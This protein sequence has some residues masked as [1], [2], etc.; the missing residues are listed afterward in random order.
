MNYFLNFE[1]FVNKLLSNKLFKLL[2]IIITF[3]CIILLIKQFES[4]RNFNLFTLNNLVPVLILI[5]ISYILQ[6]IGWSFLNSNTLNKYQIFNWLNSNLGKY[7]PFKVGVLGKRILNNRIEKVSKASSVFKLTLFEQI[8][9]FISTAILYLLIT[10]KGLL[11][12]TFCLITIYL[13]FRF[14]SSIHNRSFIFYFISEIIFLIALSLFIKN[15]NN[16]HSIKIA[17]IYMLS[18]VLSILIITAPAGLGVRE[19]LFVKIASLNYLYSPEIF[20]AIISI[21]IILIFVDIL[22]FLTSY[23][24]KYKFKYS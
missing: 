23:L 20:S 24:I 14:K 12:V 18:S 21:R 1:N 2:N 3:F 16:F 11:V 15:F 13:I 8:Y 19:M 4:I 22:I 7:L 6:S 9:I 5:F 10:L 17:I